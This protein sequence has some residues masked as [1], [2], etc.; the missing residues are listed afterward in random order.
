MVE[1]VLINIQ[2]PIDSMLY[3]FLSNQ[4]CGVTTYHRD[5][6]V[7]FYVIRANV[8]GRGTYVV[9]TY[10]NASI[11][12]FSDMDKQNHAINKCVSDFSCGQHA[13]FSQSS[14]QPGAQAMH[15]LR[16]I[17]HRRI[18]IWYVVYLK[19]YIYYPE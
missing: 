11:F 17:N 4:I 14:R 16:M 18:C 10:T 6:L 8:G 3:L 7:V 19:T 5:V 2:K 9:L 1:V 13:I 12:H 15:K